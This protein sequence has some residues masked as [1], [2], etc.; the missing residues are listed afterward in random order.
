[1]T[2]GVICDQIVPPDEPLDEEEVAIRER[3]RSL[4]LAFLAGEAK[5]PLMERH[6]SV[7]GSPGEQ[8]LV[9]GLFKVGQCSCKNRSEGLTPLYCFRQLQNSRPARLK[10]LSR[11]FSP[12]FRRSNH[13]LLE[14][15]NCWILSSPNCAPHSSPIF[16][17]TPNTFRSIPPKSTWILHCSSPRTNASH[18]QAI[19]SASSILHS[20]QSTS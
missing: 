1:M 12:P 17:L 20:P 19:C 18:I 2:L 10:Q 14:A 3:L 15:K 11:I 9:S 7:A 6:A 16:P 8:V 5:R 4:V 13:H